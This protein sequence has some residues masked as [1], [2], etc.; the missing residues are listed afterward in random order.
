MPCG[1]DQWTRL[2]FTALGCIC[3]CPA[4]VGVVILSALRLNPEYRRPG[5][6]RFANFLPWNP[7]SVGF[8]CVAVPPIRATILPTCMSNG[9]GIPCTS[10][11]MTPWGV[12]RL[13]SLGRLNTAIFLTPWYPGCLTEGTVL[14]LYLT[15]RLLETQLC[16]QSSH[17]SE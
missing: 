14:V 2:P 11:R 4:T 13:R 3:C 1:W 5:M 8:P 10:K 6:F 7:F 16:N 9:Q 12:D 15:C 17:V